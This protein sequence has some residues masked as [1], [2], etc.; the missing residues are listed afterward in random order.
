MLCTEGVPKPVDLNMDQLSSGAWGTIVSIPVTFICAGNRRKEQNLTKKTVG[1]DWGAGAVGNSVW[2]G[3][4]LCDLLAAVGITRAS[5]EHRYVHF[6]GPL[7]ELPQ[8]KT[9][10]YGTSIDI[11]WALDRERDVLLAF[12]QNGE[13][14][15]PDHGFP[16]RTLLPGCIGGRMIKWLTSMWVRMQKL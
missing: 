8:G 3:V 11:G 6:E 2:T 12:K 15:L 10:S 5:K 9:G 4:R 14:L 7:G 1:F 16:L 13:L